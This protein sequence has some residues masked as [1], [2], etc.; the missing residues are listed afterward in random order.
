MIGIEAKRNLLAPLYNQ[1]CKGGIPGHSSEI[2]AEDITRFIP[3][4]YDEAVSSCIVCDIVG[5]GNVISIGQNGA[6]LEG[7]ADSVLFNRRSSDVR[8]VSTDLNLTH[9]P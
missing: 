2:I 5:N 3:R 9:I 1:S 8:H 7:I 4:C 6:T